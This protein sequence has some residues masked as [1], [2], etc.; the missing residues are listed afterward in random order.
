MASLSSQGRCTIILL[1]CPLLLPTNSMTGFIY[2]VP[3]KFH[4]AMAITMLMKTKMESQITVSANLISI[5]YSSVPILLFAGNISPVLNC[6]LFGRRAIHPMHL[7]TWILL[8]SKAY[9]KM[10]LQTRQEI[11][12]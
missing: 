8:F 5:L 12:F 3:I 7:A 4:S 9:L 6:I 1:M 11:F 10:H 2:S